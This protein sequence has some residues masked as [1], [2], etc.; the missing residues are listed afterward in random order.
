[1]RLI[2]M[3]IRAHSNL[4]FPMMK[5]MAREANEEQFI[6]IKQINLQK[7]KLALAN[8]ASCLVEWSST[9]F[10]VFLQ[11][12]WTN[13]GRITSL[14]RGTQVFAAQHPR[15]AIVTTPEMNAWPMTGMMSS[16]VAACIWKTGNKSVPEIVLISVYADINKK[17][18]PAELAGIIKYCG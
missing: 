8:L 14:P 7:S 11:E 9:P 4:Q 15:A 6:F 1:M 3:S 2:K 12:P 10:F 5:R 17:A 16:D 18:V 13:N